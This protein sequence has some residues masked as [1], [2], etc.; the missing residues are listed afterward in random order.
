MELHMNRPL[1]PGTVLNGVYEIRELFSPE[2]D[3][4]VLAY[5]AARDQKLCVILELYPIELDC[6]PG[7]LELDIT[8]DTFPQYR[9]TF[10]ENSR[11]A[12]CDLFF[13]KV[14]DKFEENNTAYIVTEYIREPPPVP[15]PGCILLYDMDCP[16][17]NI[18]MSELERLHRHGFIHG[19]ISP[20]FCHRTPNPFILQLSGMDYAQGID[21]S[22]YP[23]ILCHGFAPL[24]L[25]MQSGR[26]GPW[27]DVYGLAA[28][29][30]YFMTG[31]IPPSAV[32]RICG[33]A[34]TPPR[35]LGARMTESQ[36]QAMLKALSVK[37]GDR[38]QT[39]EEFRLALF[40]EAEQAQKQQEQL[41]QQRNREFQEEIDRLVLE[42][43]ENQKQKNTS[44]PASGMDP[45]K[46]PG[47][48]GRFFH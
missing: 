42:H 19:R 6:K 47:F 41:Q 27:T 38:F 2:T 5:L 23:A 13:P 18:T 31:R 37:S 25:Y 15:G 20:A 30:Y 12:W 33:E 14:L 24:E 48:F 21:R 4:R 46:K 22:R 29:M 32:D 8:D 39:M 11:A 45:Q 9:K 1:P 28:T 40:G 3:H 34:L 26:R 43:S 44:D 35:Q 16:W 36:E 7:S 17:A 10:L